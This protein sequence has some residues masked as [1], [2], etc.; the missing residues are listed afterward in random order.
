MLTC[1]AS[2]AGPIGGTRA[3]VVRSVRTGHARASVITRVAVARQQHL[4]VGAGET[5]QTIA[6]IGRASVYARTTINAR[7][8]VADQRI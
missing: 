2:S 6:L 7:T 5:P 1:L 8:A 4:A 3:R